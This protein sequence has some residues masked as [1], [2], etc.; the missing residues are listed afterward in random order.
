MGACYAKGRGEWAS[1]R[2]F[3]LSIWK[4][5]F[6]RGLQPEQ[7]FKEEE[8]EGDRGNGS[9]CLS[10]SSMRCPPGSLSHGSVQKTWEDKGEAWDGDVN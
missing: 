7:V 10:M 4:T 9:L 8:R 2:D 6:Q 3:I 5:H 1:C